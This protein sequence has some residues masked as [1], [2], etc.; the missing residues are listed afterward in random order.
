[1][2][3]ISL[4]APKSNQIKSNQIIKQGMSSSFPDKFLSCWGKKKLDTSPNLSNVTSQ[5]SSP[6]TRR[7]TQST[8]VLL[9]EKVQG[10]D[11]PAGFYVYIVHLQLFNH[12]ILY[13]D[14]LFLDMNYLIF[15]NWFCIRTIVTFHSV[16]RSFSH[17]ILDPDHL[18]LI[19]Y[20][21]PDH[22]IS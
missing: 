16:F 2:F 21:Y 9:N 10:Y 15:N 22:L 8:E 20:L 14:H 13:L 17:L 19:R 11:P 1:M 5:R 6:N 3:N 12:L 7:Q 4:Q 18:F